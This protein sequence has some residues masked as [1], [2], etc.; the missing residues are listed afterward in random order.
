MGQHAQLACLDGVL[1]RLD[2]VRLAATASP[3][4]P[5]EEL[6]AQ[7]VDPAICHR[8]SAAEVPRLT[9]A[10][11]RDAIAA[12]ALYGRSQTERKPSDAELAELTGAA[13][14]D[15]CAR[16][17][18]TLAFESASRDTPRVR[19]LMTDAAIAVDQ[20]G[21]DRLRAEFLIQDSPYH[22]ELPIIGPRGEAAI[23]QA[24]VAA[25]RVMQPDIA[26]QLAGQTSQIENQRGRWSEAMA[27]TDAR[28]TG[29]Q[30]RGLLRRAL[31]GVV[32]RDFFRV[33]HSEPEDLAAVL[34]DVRAWRPIAAARRD[35]EGIRGLDIMAASARLRRGDLSA[36]ADLIQQ[37]RAQ[38]PRDP[39]PGTQR[40]T[41]EIV[42]ARG[43]PVAGARVACSGNLAA[44]SAGLG[45]PLLLNHEL[46]DDALQIAT[47]DDAGRFVIEHA[48]PDSAIAAEL[49]DLRSLPAAAV[50]RVRLVL[51]PTR[52][53]SGRVALAHTAATRV[54]VIVLVPADPTGR[55][56]LGARVAA[57]GTFTLSG[58]PTGA[59]RIG[60][61]VREP[62]GIE[63]NIAFQS[64]PASP[65]PLAG[66]ALDLVQSDRAVDVVVRSAVTATLP[67]AQVLILPG[68]LE[69]QSV[70]DLLRL[71][72]RGVQVRMA[73][74]A[75]S[76]PAASP[77]GAPLRG[78]D[79]VAHIEHV[80][81]GALTVCAIGLSG[82]L[83]DP[84]AMRRLQSH[85]AQIAMRCEHASPT[86][87][88]VVLTVPPQQRF[89]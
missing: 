3:G 17:I 29:F 71:Q 54:S 38:P 19:A 87:R 57:D 60:V 6:R 72:G 7:L 36:H 46:R 55:F 12:I 64:L 78:D 27:A 18:A 70:N 84:A 9:V 44:D 80:A 88:T 40:I 85:I 42:D 53:L 61:Q 58:V 83:L 14:A 5:A 43:R 23:R 81:P 89:D 67:G 77:A 79:L 39:L 66:I 51:A 22:W 62:S 4:V 20:C 68:T 59:V 65:G 50:D 30:A 56:S 86:T 15:P 37:W 52:S 35:T 74:P 1:A 34:A 75:G 49:G 25:T 28:I 31:R 2:A 73:A 45:L 26:A 10:P 76:S 41:G 63:E 11:T 13:T 48:A 8:A 24:R 21:D 82:D 69:I 32:W 47:S 33:M 16:V